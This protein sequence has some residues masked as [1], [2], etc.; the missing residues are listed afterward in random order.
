MTVIVTLRESSHNRASGLRD[1]RE[2]RGIGPSKARPM[3]ADLA[4]DCRDSG[5]L[6]GDKTEYQRVLGRADKIGTESIV[7]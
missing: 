4:P 6:S 2:V 3:P 7:T 1:S 5:E